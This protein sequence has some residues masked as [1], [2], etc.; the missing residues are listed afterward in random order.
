MGRV[1][2]V[3]PAGVQTHFLI[4][5][6]I[7]SMRFSILLRKSIAPYQGPQ[8][9]L[10]PLS[11]LSGLC[12]GHCVCESLSRVRLFVTPWT[13]ACQASLSMEFSRQEYWG[14]LPCPSPGDLPDPGIE[15]MSPSLQSD[16]LPTEPLS[17]D[18]KSSLLC[19]N[20]HS[21]C[22][23]WG[24][25]CPYP[26]EDV[27]WDHPISSQQV[28]LA[29]HFYMGWEFRC[30]EAFWLLLQN[31]HIHPKFQNVERVF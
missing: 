28:S 14:G 12:S 10:W 5:A 9:Q 30:L 18:T 22:L 2:L 8:S 21:E 15:P 6:N 26:S 25:Q 23:F 11:P 19:S 29:F 31:G 16:S 4:L 20:P 1:W 24:P 13:V 3:S 17:Q 7:L 27:G